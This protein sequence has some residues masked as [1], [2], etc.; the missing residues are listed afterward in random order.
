MIRSSWE[1][2]FKIGNSVVIYQIDQTSCIPY[3][4]IHFY[5]VAR[6]LIF[7]I[8]VQYVKCLLDFL[9]SSNIRW[10]MIF[11]INVKVFHGH[12]QKVCLSLDYY[13]KVKIILKCKSW[14]SEKWRC[15]EIMRLL[16]GKTDFD[17]INSAEQKVE[18]T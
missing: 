2:S 6:F 11:D 1:E 13:W 4:C 12:E 18:N 9:F 15:Y 3:V 16:Y 17:I 7:F 14:K 10:K 8:N 5:M